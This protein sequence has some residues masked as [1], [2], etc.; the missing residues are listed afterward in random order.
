MRKHC[1]SSSQSAQCEWVAIAKQTQQAA[2]VEH[3]LN[4]LVDALSSLSFNAP[5]VAAKLELEAVQSAPV[6]KVE[7][8]ELASV[9]DGATPRLRFCIMPR[10][11]LTLRLKFS[12]QKSVA[13]S[14]EAM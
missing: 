8:P 3:L 14:G 12:L 6:C 1:I 9:G 13:R 5:A 11:S 2:L 10:S 7:R 4:L